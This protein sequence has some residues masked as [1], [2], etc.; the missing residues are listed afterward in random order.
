MRDAFGEGTDNVEVSRSPEETAD[1]EPQKNFNHARPGQKKN[2]VLISAQNHEKDHEGSFEYEDVSEPPPPQTHKIHSTLTRSRIR[3]NNNANQFN[4]PNSFTLPKSS[5]RTKP[6]NGEKFEIVSIEKSKSHSYYGG[7]QPEN[8]FLEGYGLSKRSDN[9][10]NEFNVGMG[11]SFGG[12]PSVSK[13][14]TDN[15]HLQDTI[16]GV[17]RDTDLLPSNHKF[18]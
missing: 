7:S 10:V 15:S 1:F 9:V 8:E 5:S 18:S 6:S 16:T 14:K 13:V 2:F 4:F 11:I 12:P 3:N 17:W